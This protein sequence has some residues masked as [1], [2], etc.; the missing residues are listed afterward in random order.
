MTVIDLV[1]SIRAICLPQVK[2]IKIWTK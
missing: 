2:D 1:Y